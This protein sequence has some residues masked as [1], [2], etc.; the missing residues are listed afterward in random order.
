MRGVVWAPVV[1]EPDPEHLLVRSDGTIAEHVLMILH[2]DMTG[3]IQAGARC[4]NCLEPFL[5]DSWPDQCPVC[6]FEVRAKQAQRF[7]QEFKGNI[8]VGPSTTIDEELAI[9]E[10][11]VERERMESRLGIRSTSSI[12]VPRMVA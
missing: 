10:E 11:L 7:D 8:R 5:N 6:G 4:L 3:Q 2:E 9:A 12:A 1:T